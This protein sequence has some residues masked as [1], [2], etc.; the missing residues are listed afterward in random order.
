MLLKIGAFLAMLAVGLTNSDCPVAIE[1]KCVDEFKEALPYCKKVF[2]NPKDFVA[3]INCL[4]YGHTTGV[5]CWPC[6]CYAAKAENV[7][8]K[9]CD[10]VIYE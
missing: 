3:D 8:I 4:K 9:G 1:K 2:E 7:K 5:D 6:L 10:N